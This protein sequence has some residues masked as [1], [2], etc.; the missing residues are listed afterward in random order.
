MRNKLISEK[1]QQVPLSLGGLGLGT[2]G[3]AFAWNALLSHFGLNKANKPDYDLS[4]LI[5]TIILA[6]LSLLYIIIM[7]IKFALNK[8]SIFSFL[9]DPRQAGFVF[10][11]FM[12]ISSFGNFL[13]F[14]NQNYFDNTFWFS[15]ILNIIVNFATLCHVLALIYFINVVLA[16]HDLDKD[17]VYASWTMPLVGLGIS[18]GFYNNLGIN[19]KGY[20]TYFQILWLVCGILFLAIFLL[21]GYKQYFKGHKDKNDIASMAIMA[22]PPN[23][24]LVGFL[25]SFDPNLTQNSLIHLNAKYFQIIVYILFFFGI[26]GIFIYFS[27]LIKLLVIKQ[28]GV[29]WVSLTFSSAITAT[30]M[31]KIIDIFEPL[32]VEFGGLK[33]VLITIGLIMISVGSIITSYLNVYVFVK[34]KTWFKYRSQ[35]HVTGMI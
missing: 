26:V 19:N 22:S 8:K 2:I 16:K 1:F 23:L 35:V 10:P 33:N 15:I 24:L 32:G 3:I 7:S 11:F 9:K 20:L 14:L 6:T 21:V 31:F 27:T 4:I 17:E 5:I 29:A 12:A 25:V 34:F 28:S 18:T 30:S 13:G